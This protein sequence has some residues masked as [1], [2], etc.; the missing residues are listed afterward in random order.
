MGDGLVL[1]GGQPSGLSPKD[2]REKAAHPT[3]SLPPA[4]DDREKASHPTTS[5]LQMTNDY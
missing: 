2:D 4:K 1:E 5:L 3:T